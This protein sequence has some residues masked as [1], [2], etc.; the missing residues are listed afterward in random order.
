MTFV[1]TLSPSP[2]RLQV[3]KELFLPKWTDKM[4]CHKVD[5]FSKVSVIEKGEVLEIFYLKNV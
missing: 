2:Q 1:T 3:Y 5:R 4:D